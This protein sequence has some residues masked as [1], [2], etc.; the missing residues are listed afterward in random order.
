MYMKTINKFI[1]Y[2]LLVS[3]LSFLGFK[4]D[5]SQSP[6][7]N[8][9]EFRLNAKKRLEYCVKAGII[10]DPDLGYI[11]NALYKYNLVKQ[12]IEDFYDQFDLN[13]DKKLSL[14]EA[15]MFYYWVKRNIKY[16]YDD[17]K[18]ENPKPNSLIGDKREGDD[19]RQTSFETL[20]ERAGD[21]EDMS[22][23]QVDFFSHFGYSSYI[24]H[25]NLLEDEVVDH[26]ISI[27][28]MDKNKKEWKESLDNMMLYFT[29]TKSNTSFYTG[30]NNFNQGDYMVV[31]ASYS[32]EFALIT[33]FYDKDKC[34]VHLI[35]SLDGPY[36]N[37]WKTA[38]LQNSKS[39]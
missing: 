32:D 13:K 23:L 33:R 28:F 37:Q 30:I 16:R 10:K 7:D 29:L 35:S 19:Y 9:G 5:Q 27:L 17:E 36:G 20:L 18:I 24:G 3:N 15:A 22:T 21:C 8:I 26:A 25:V 6:Q 39:Y 11:P 14:Q 38:T 34:R 12:Q 31:D 4:A 1:T 2:T